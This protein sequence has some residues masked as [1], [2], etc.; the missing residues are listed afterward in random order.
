MSYA[1]LAASL[2]SALQRQ[3]TD[4]IHHLVAEMQLAAEMEDASLAEL[5]HFMDAD[6]RTDLFN[7]DGVGVLIYFAIATAVLGLPT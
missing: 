6:E 3:D 5:M 7:A 2:R 4:A 1:V